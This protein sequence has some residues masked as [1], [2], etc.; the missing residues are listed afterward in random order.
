LIKVVGDGG[1][2][3]A[4]FPSSATL[5]IMITPRE[6]IRATTNRG[7]P[8][9][10]VRWNRRI[11]GS[12]PDLRFWVFRFRLGLWCLRRRRRFSYDVNGL[13][14]QPFRWPADWR[15]EGPSIGGMRKVIIS[16]YHK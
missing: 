2:E 15:R 6:P 3:K 7:L 1:V 9:P 14:G 12:G 5:A 10:W 8:A 16:V 11:L 4:C 13:L